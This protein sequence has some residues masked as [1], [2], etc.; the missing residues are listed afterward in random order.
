VFKGGYGV[1]CGTSMATPHA[2]GV[3]A[4]L[5]SKYHSPGPWTLTVLLE[6]QSDP[7][8]CATAAPACS[9]SARDNTYYGHGLVNALDAVK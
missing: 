5:A 9:G 6:Q 1:K 7:V 4:L 8:A 3:A 2:A